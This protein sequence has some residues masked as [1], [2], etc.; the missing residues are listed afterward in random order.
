ME[1][2]LHKY[3]INHDFVDVFVCIVAHFLEETPKAVL[4]SACGDRMPVRFDGRQVEH[5]PP[6][7]KLRNFNA[8]WEDLVE[9]EERTLN[10]YTIHSTS[11]EVGTRALTQANLFTAP[12]RIRHDGFVV[13]RG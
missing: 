10:G 2:P 5:L 1:F 4:D 11:E 12:F 8:L 9:A 13:N 7:I 6:R 3:Q